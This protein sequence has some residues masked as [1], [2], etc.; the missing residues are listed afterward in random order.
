[1]TARRS[2]PCWTGSPVPWRPSPAMATTTRTTFMPGSRRGIRCRRHCPSACW[3]AAARPSSVFRN[4]DP[5]FRGGDT[6]MKG[7]DLL[8]G[9]GVGKID[10]DHAPAKLVPI[11]HAKR[12]DPVS[13]L[14]DVAC[15]QP[16]NRPSP[17]TG[18]GEFLHRCAKGVRVFGVDRVAYSDQHWVLRRIECG[19]KGLV[20]VDSRRKTHSGNGRVSHLVRYRQQS[21]HQCHDDAP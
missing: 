13:W 10:A 20:D 3:M 17:T 14:L 6:S 15:E 11:L 4:Q 21:R 1:M 16:S 18:R 5:R 19:S 12:L 2:V 9:F 7:V 8:G